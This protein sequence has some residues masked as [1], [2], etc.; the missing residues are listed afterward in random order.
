VIPSIAAGRHLSVRTALWQL[1][2]V[3]VVALAWLLKG[4]VW[5]LAAAIAGGAVALGGW[6]AARV[7]L[8]G[9]A[10]SAGMALSRMLLGLGLKW[11]VVIGTLAVCMRAELPALALLAGAVA[12]V[13]AQM[14][15]MFSQTKM[16]STYYVN[17]G[18]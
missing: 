16:K 3:G 17:N 13:I 18:R 7:A 1:A 6:L 8:A 4:G 12:A 14:L 15:V 5:A 11:G 2:S 10:L 9:G